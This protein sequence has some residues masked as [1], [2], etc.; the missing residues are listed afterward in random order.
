MI[1]QKIPHQLYYLLELV[2]LLLGFYIIFF[3]T[4]FNFQILALALMLVLYT[5]IGLIHQKLHHG[6]RGKIV[7]EYILVSAVLFAVFLFLNISKF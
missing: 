2:A 3:L 1:L 6:L 7:V 4:G 5:G